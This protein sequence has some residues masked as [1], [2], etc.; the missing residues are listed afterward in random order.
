S[1]LPSTSSSASEGEAIKIARTASRIPSAVRMRSIGR[2]CGLVD[3]IAPLKLHLAYC[4]TI[5]IPIHAAYGG[6]LKFVNLDGAVEVVIRASMWAR[7]KLISDLVLE[8][9]RLVSFGK[10]VRDFE[11]GPVF[12]VRP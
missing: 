5:A 10:A 1:R 8:A 4:P 11:L 3:I 2:M 6:V 9:I 7:R 12:V